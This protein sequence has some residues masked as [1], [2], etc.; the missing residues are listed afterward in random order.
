MDHQE[1]TFHEFKNHGSNHD[2]QY[3]EEID[4]NETF[5]FTVKRC[6]IKVLMTILNQYNLMLDQMDVQ[7]PFLHGDLAETI[8]MEQP[9]WLLYFD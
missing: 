2:L 1:E 8:Y 9:V 3:K 6:S 4:Y 7:T 5:T